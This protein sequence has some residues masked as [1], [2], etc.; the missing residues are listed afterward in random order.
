ML[1]TVI[2]LLLPSALWCQITI[3][4]DFSDGDYANM[5]TWSG[6]TVFEVD[7]AFELHLNDVAAGG[8]YLSTNSAIID[9][10]T[11]Q[12]YARMEFNPSSSNYFKVYLV[13]DRADVSGNV[14]G[15]YV[16][17]GGSSAD[18]I[19][20]YRQS[21]GTSSLV[22]E[23]TDDWV[24]LNAVEVGIKVTRDSSGFWVL[25]ADTAGGT[26]YTAIDSAFDNTHSISTYFGLEC[27]YTSTRSDKFFFD[28]FHLS[29]KA[30]S[31]TKSPEINEVQV[32]NSTS[33]DV[34]FTESVT[35]VSAE[36][37]VNYSI[38]N[39]IGQPVS[40]VLDNDEFT[41]HLTLA[42]P[43][44]SR[45]QYQLNI[46]GI[47][48]LYNNL[49]KDSIDFSFYIPALGDII[50]NELMIDPNPVIGIP[51]NALPERE[52]VEVYNTTA[53]PISL[54][55][56]T[57]EVGSSIE[58][59]PQISL[60]GGGYVVF[61]K[62]EG[63]SEFPSGLP[64]VGLDM[65]SVALTN[66]GN[67]VS[68]FAPGNVV[69]S[70]V[71]YTSDW[72]KDENK[73]GGGWSLELIDPENRCGG[74]SNWAASTS[75]S[76]GTPGLPNS[77][78]GSNPDTLAPAF[79]RISILGDST[80]MVFFS[81]SVSDSVLLNPANFWIDPPLNISNLQLVPPAFEGVKVHFEEPIDPAIVYQF[82]LFNFP[83]D[84]SNNQM[85]ADSLIFTI[86]AIPEEGEI[87][88]NEILFNP[89]SGGSDFV[90]V[91]NNSN[92]IFDLSKLRFGNYN[93]TFNTAE[94]LKQITEESYLFEP[95][96]YLVFS[97]NPSFITSNYN[98]KEPLNLIKPTESLPSMDD[99]EGSIS[100]VTSDLIRVID[101]FEYED[102]MHIAS[103][104]DKEA[105]S[106][107]RVSF[108]KSTMDRDNW[109]SAASTAGYGTPGYIN[110]QYY[111]PQ[112]SGNITLEPRVFS[113]NQDGYNDLLKILYDFPNPNNVVSVG[114][115]SS[116]GYE[117]VKLVN[118]RSVSGSGFFTWDGVDDSG[119]LMNSGIYIVVVEYFHENGTS[120]MLKETC[121]LSR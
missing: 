12:F 108:T 72:Y 11:W 112:N 118:A 89:I 30:F 37:L 17:V 43:L 66:S 38:D 50:I 3:V 35:K 92:K 84:C 2:L 101:Y 76:G 8:A 26:N 23:S 45:Q 62:D 83:Q 80:I 33:I 87:L 9:D 21:G 22:A 75:I 14:N 85:R 103:L 106:L 98:V 88:I 113:P 96:R 13:S 117:V 71:A 120:G 82:S 42:S 81:E 115:W 95:G 119:M 53:F 57:L 55:N 15:Y 61:T 27:T 79:N 78:L 36:T 16:R 93:S 114:I 94:N 74:S 70:S 121:V 24:D 7:T 44:L 60:P 69:I 104:R 59:L 105:V 100:V 29:G 34:L 109:Q 6:D 52:Y 1:R 47:S 20:L 91:Y 58:L 64:I 5:P 46:D 107:E 54:E 116:D 48:D 4:D 32:I 90:E 68:L 56:W 67:T 63:V 25:Y 99:S 39:G 110:S 102:D 65:S 77:I 31:D 49:A 41:V 40:A 51:P 19:S 28:N 111:S 97:N 10:A 73:E 18:R 86:P